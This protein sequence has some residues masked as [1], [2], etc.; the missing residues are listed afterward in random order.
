MK[1]TKFNWQCVHCGKKNIKIIKF[2][3]DIPKQYSAQWK[4]GKCTKETKIVLVF[5]I[6]LPE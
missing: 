3:F 2:Q 4:C 6:A 1:N 5:S